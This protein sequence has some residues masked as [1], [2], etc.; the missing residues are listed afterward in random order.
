MRPVSYSIALTRLAQELVI[1]QTAADKCILIK[2]MAP[3]LAS[4]YGT[5]VSRAMEDLN[6]QLIKTAKAADPVGV[7]AWKT[8]ISLGGEYV[9]DNTK[10]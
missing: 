10:F 1:M 3:T 2:I 4:I 9:R 8:T 5:S 7:A 6:K